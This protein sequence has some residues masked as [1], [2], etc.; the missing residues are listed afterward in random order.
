MGR[1]SH[2]HRLTIWLNGTPIGYWET[3]HGRNTLSYFDEWL[4]DEQARPL[5]LSLPFMP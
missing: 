4:D 2:A 3:S 5:S 1:Q